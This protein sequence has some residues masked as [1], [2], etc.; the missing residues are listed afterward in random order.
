[1]AESKIKLNR[2]IKKSNFGLF[3]Y[4]ARKMEN[5]CNSLLKDDDITLKQLLYIIILRSQYDSPPGVKEMGKSMST[6]HQNSM[7]IARNLEKKGLLKLIRD[8]KD[9][10]VWRVYMPK[11][12]NEIWKSRGGENSKKLENLFSCLSL[13][14]QTAFNSILVKMTE[15]LIDIDTNSKLN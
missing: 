4:L 11:E 3:F 9:K 1:M 15:H 13:E 7:I 10:R 6:S 8:T 12:A 5:V 2:D 14:E